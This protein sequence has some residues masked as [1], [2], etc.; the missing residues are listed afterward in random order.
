MV[1][2]END[3]DNFDS[4]ELT[5][6]QRRIAGRL[7]AKSPVLAKWFV[8]GCWLTVARWPETWPEL[9]AHTGRDIMDRAFEH[10]DVPRG[11]AVQYKSLTMTLDEQLP[12]DLDSLR[13]LVLTG[14]PLKRF[15][16]LIRAHRTDGGARVTLAELAAAAGRPLPPMQSAARALDIVWSE[17]RAGLNKAVH[18]R[19]RDAAVAKP[20]EVL[21]LWDRLEELLAGQLQGVP[22]WDLD[23]GL[24]ELAKTPNPTVAQLQRALALM[25]G[26]ASNTFFE[27]LSDPAWLSPMRELKL[28][29]EPEPAEQLGGG[30][31]RLPDW[32]LSRYLTRIASRE[33]AAVVE[34]IAAIP[35]T[36]NGRIHDDFLEAALAMPVEHATRLADIAVDW[37]G[38]PYPLAAAFH[39]SQL[40][41]KLAREG[42]LGASMALAR[43]VFAVQAEPQTRRQM[44]GQGVEFRHNFTRLYSY[45]EGVEELVATL[46]VVAPLATVEL[47]ADLLDGALTASRAA[48]GREG[49]EDDSCWLWRMAIEDHEQNLALD[50][51]HNAL[52]TALRNAAEHAITAH[53]DLAADV[54]DALAHH[55]HLIFRR[56][57]LHLLRI[58]EFPG[59]EDRRREALLDASLFGDDAVRREVFLL[60]RDCF[61]VLR[62]D[63]QEIVL[64]RMWDD[65]HVEAWARRRNDQTGEAPTE[66]ECSK[67]VEARRLGRLQAVEAFLEG[68]WKRRADELIARHGR[69]AHPDFV[70]YVSTDWQPIDDTVEPER[71]GAMPAEELTDLMKTWRPSTDRLGFAGRED[72]LAMTLTKSVIGDPEGWATR[73]AEFVDAPPLY[74][75]HLLSGFAAAADT[76]LTFDWATVFDFATRVLP[77]PQPSTRDT[78]ARDVLARALAEL[79]CA[80]FQRSEVRPPPELRNRVWLLI[81]ALAAIVETGVGDELDLSLTHRYVPPTTVRS[82]AVE[83]AI[84]YAAWIAAAPDGARP[85]HGLQTVPEVRAVLER[86]FEDDDRDPAA[87][88]AMAKLLGP[89][90]WLDESWTAE[91][92]AQ[93]FAEQPTAGWLTVWARYLIAPFDQRVAKMLLPAAYAAAVR[94]FAAD[95]AVTERLRERLG[96]HVMLLRLYGLP[97]HEPAWQAWC[98]SASPGDRA[99][100]VRWVGTRVQAMPEDAARNL[101]GPMLVLWRER[102][103]LLGET[104]P[105]RAAYGT[106][107]ATGTLPHA[108]AADLLLSTVEGSGGRLE[109]LR[110][111][112][113]AAETTVAYAPQPVLA[114]MRAVL[115]G[116]NAEQLG[117]SHERLRSVLDVAKALGIPEVTGQVDQLVGELGERGHDLR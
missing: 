32:P 117:W 39:A 49:P 112:L 104:D 116:A 72:A 87:L 35:A 101:S 56:V 81:E 82:Q 13:E 86:V 40:A 76:G 26:D 60:Q 18:L 67:Y 37:L 8:S 99:Q 64:G 44:L 103:G 79:A 21:A 66:E 46:Q 95:A 73:A 68:R 115:H 74:Q 29:D 23:A 91:H 57:A 55:P 102:L 7:S 38:C 45:E 88:G 24:N 30:Y 34:V 59:V 16:T 41:A 42:D 54:L 113:A 31:F 3:R 110:R 77:D 94:A 12:E 93:L 65:H 10:F 108:D 71:L 106:W 11:D 17:T 4:V 75:A 90:A 47:L 62:A 80:A 85:A 92:V 28:F 69:A 105:E 25:R 53:P 83:A 19:G 33:P 15:K 36:D 27:S 5:E 52:V 84:K 107:F 6:R 78:P 61:G 97:E 50:E 9:L 89:L 48:S 111:V 98:D 14:K 96:F 109:D 1:A 58:A 63:E 2:T 43:I 20:D 22:F 51:P 100:A 70:S 114:G